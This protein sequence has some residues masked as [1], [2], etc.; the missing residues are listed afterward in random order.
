M[1]RA[2][3][4]N[5]VSFRSTAQIVLSAA[6]LRALA[7]VGAGCGAG[8]A[9]D[10][11]S[12]VCRSFG[13]CDEPKPKPI[14]LAVICDS[15]T[16]S[17]CT[18]ETLRANLDLLLPW[19]T[20]RPSSNAELW[21]L[22]LEVSDTVLVATESFKEELKSGRA[23]KSQITRLVETA[24]STL[25][26]AGKPY[27]TGEIR[28]SP[29]A[30]SLTK[31]ALSRARPDSQRVI[32]AITDAREYSGLY[33]FECGILPDQK[34]FVR[35][36]ALNHLFPAGS[37]AQTRVFFSFVNLNRVENNRCPATV[38]RAAQIEELWTSAI[39]GAGA[40]S[41]QFDTGVAQVPEALNEGHR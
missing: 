15:T 30:E 28:R 18:P 37:L 32:V 33:D 41:V 11:L 8:Q 14:E 5:A 26:T 29:L 27:F 36:M 40:D 24:R 19:I 9:G 1:T 7:L 10:R 20:G 31:V 2:T 35:T 3:N 6:T 34:K 16:G 23:R 17:T 21:F 22:G 38:A 12:G 25:L 13:I 4:Q 39:R